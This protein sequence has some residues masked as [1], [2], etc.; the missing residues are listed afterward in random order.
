VDDQDLRS[1]EDGG[2]ATKRILGEHMLGDK[3]LSSRI[4]CSPSCLGFLTPLIPCTAA[5]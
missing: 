3:E 1:A 5:G 2:T 4:M